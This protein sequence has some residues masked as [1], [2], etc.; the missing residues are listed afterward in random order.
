MVFELYSGE[1][2][3]L[4]KKGFENIEDL[5]LSID[6]KNGSFHDVGQSETLWNRKNKMD[7]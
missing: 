3:E 5:N 2:T 7:R 4:A 6:Y 1:L